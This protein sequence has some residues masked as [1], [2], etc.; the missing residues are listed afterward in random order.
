MVGLCRPNNLLN[1]VIWAEKSVWIALSL[2][3]IKTQGISGQV[4][5]LLPAARKLLM[6]LCMVDML[7]DALTDA[8]VDALLMLFANGNQSA[9]TAL[10]QRLSPR[11]LAHAYR[12]L[13]DRSEAEDVTQYAVV[14]LSKMEPDWRQGEAK[15]TT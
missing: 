15:V 11:V 2:K 13:G 12:L 5:R 4:P 7:L 1:C 8:S 14:R 10:T 6:F 9:A 3:L